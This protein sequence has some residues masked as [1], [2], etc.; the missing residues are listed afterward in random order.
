MLLM[1]VHEAN[2]SLA[3][4]LFRR[5]AVSASLFRIKLKNP[6]CGKFIST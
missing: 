6:E 5:L 3:T 4:A 2:S 1:L